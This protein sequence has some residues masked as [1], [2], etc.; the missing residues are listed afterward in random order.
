VARTTTFDFDELPR[1]IAE[2]IRHPGFAVV[3]VLTQC[4]TFYGRPNGLGDAAAM[5]DYERDQTVPVERITKEDLVGKLPLG[6]FRQAE[7]TEYV[8]EYAALCAA[9]R[10][11]T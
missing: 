4:P 7:G 2:A 11:E 6:V 1:R 5:L 8:R 3:E 9:S 10:G